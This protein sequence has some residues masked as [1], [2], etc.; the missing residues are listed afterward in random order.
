MRL[1]TELFAEQIASCTGKVGRDRSVFVSINNN[2]MAGVRKNHGGS[3]SVF[4]RDFHYPKFV[5]DRAFG[6][7]KHSHFAQSIFTATVDRDLRSAFENFDGT[8]LYIF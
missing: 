4:L 7:G 2:G 8:G 1:R 6:V 5:I 3:T